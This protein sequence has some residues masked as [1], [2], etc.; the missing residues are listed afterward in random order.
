MG[1]EGQVDNG[2]AS[3]VT[4]SC[5]STSSLLV[6][7]GRG[8]ALSSPELTWVERYVFP[9]L[10]SPSEYPL[11]EQSVQSL[12]GGLI[13]NVDRG[14]P[15]WRLNP[16]RCRCFPC[17]HHRPHLWTPWEVSHS[18]SWLYSLPPARRLRSGLA[19]LGMLPSP[20]RLLFPAGC[21]H[22][23]ACPP[24]CLENSSW[25]D[26]VTATFL[27]GFHPGDVLS[28]LRMPAAPGNER[29]TRIR[30]PWSEGSLD[31][32]KTI[33]KERCTRICTIW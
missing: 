33:C 30:P 7:H 24:T 25:G 14:W 11:Q 16:R 27:G 19:G 4:K 28:P 10:S 23:P 26:P 29:N 31:Y 12:T 9:T 18:V 32:R 15:C 8:A 22:P 3:S 5:V 6:R 13:N 21:G 20:G 17:G 1:R 2:A